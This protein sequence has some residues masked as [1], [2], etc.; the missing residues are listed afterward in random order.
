M[1]G[2]MADELA[3]ELSCFL[4]RRGPPR[5]SRDPVNLPT[6]R[7]WCDALGEQSAIF[8]DAASAEHAG[9]PGVVAPAAMLGVWTMPANLAATDHRQEDDR[10]QDPLASV[11]ERL[12]AA[13][14]SSVVATGI[15]E[16]YPRYLRVGETVTG[17]RSIGEISQVKQT[18]L[19]RGHFVTTE[20]AY[21][22]DAGE[23]LGR[24]TFVLLKFD[25]STARRPEHPESERERASEK[26]AG[27]ERPSRPLPGISRD[28]RFFW[29]GLEAGELRIQR[30]EG[31]G[32]LAHPP[33]VRC[34]ACGSYEFGYQVASGRASVYSF[35]EPCHP[36][37]PMFDYP[38]VVGLVELEE[39]TRLITNVVDVDA[40]DVEIGMPVELV[41]RRPDGKL[42]LPL[43]RPAA[44]PRRASPRWASQVRQ[45]ERLPLCPI[46]VTAKLVIGGALATCDYQDV[47]HDRD[48]A[49]AR[50]MKD[51]FMNIYTTL[52]LCTRYAGD[53]AGPGA[54]IRSLSLRLG[55][56]NY[57]GDVMTLAATV[58]SVDASGTAQLA[59]RGRNSL[60]DH[61]TGTIV[62]ELAA[63]AAE[64]EVAR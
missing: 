11:L 14:F 38:Y 41:L 23:L 15:S 5:R 64:G 29:D 12:D 32:R 16:D 55:A 43:F 52:G 4:S 30:C 63:A 33:L 50:G 60:G 46:D 20:T 42:L 57:P 61:V 26:A 1:P 31:C 48:A 19:G 49:R 56:P 53:W 2:A 51:V 22:N 37:L 35:V 58:R 25:P 62:V 6:I 9:L 36:K 10:Q 18:A 21:H 28:T 7:R 3:S 27:G 8:A 13:G 39:G 17:L 54:R 47:H 24:S 44:T 40:D 34:P 59:I 45:G